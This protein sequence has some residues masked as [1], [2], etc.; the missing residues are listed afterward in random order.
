LGAIAVIIFQG[1]GNGDSPNALR[2]AS[3]F[4]VPLPNLFLEMFR[5]KSF[6][7]GGNKFWRT[8]DSARRLR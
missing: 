2:N 7:V 3:C 8:L 6:Y 5:L 1:V 4:A